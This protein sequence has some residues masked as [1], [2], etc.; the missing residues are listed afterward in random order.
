MTDTKSPLRVING[1]AYVFDNRKASIIE[2]EAVS[3]DNAEE[4]AEEVLCALEQHKHIYWVVSRK[5]DEEEKVIMQPSLDNVRQVFLIGEE[6]KEL[7]EWLDNFGVTHQ[8]IQKME[9]AVLEA[10]AIAQDE[11]GEPGGAGTVMLTSTNEE[12]IERY[13]K[14]VQELPDDVETD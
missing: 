3:E 14:L 6:D 5:P 11:R 7:E 9:A 12:R 8:R 13:K 1:V 4:T 10:H 2:N